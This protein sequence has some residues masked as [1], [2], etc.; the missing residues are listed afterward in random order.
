MIVDE[1][2][3]TLKSMSLCISLDD[4][5]EEIRTGL[6]D[7]SPQMRLNSLKFLKEFTNAK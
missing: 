5:Q 6:K 7:K 4:M 3:V 2:L 1:T